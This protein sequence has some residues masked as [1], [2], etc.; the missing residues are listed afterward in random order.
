M[1]FL[2][3]IVFVTEELTSAGKGEEHEDSYENHHGAHGRHEILIRLVL[4][5]HIATRFE[6]F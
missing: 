5:E 3:S 6:D 2:G 4:R 1:Q